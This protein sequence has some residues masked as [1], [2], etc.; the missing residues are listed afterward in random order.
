MGYYQY[1]G[2]GGKGPIGQAILD[3]IHVSNA[4]KY[5]YKEPDKRK[6]LK[7]LITDKEPMVQDLLSGLKMIRTDSGT[8]FLNNGSTTC[9]DLSQRH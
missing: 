4:L 6:R 5:R 1:P 8:E 7:L 3:N 9:V 2:K